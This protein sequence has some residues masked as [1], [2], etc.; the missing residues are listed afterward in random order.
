MAFYETLDDFFESPIGEYACSWEIEQYKKIVSE[1]FGYNAVQL[2]APTLD[3]LEGNQ[4]GLK[5]VCDTELAFITKIRDS[6]ETASI[7]FEELPFETESIDL[8]LLPHTLEAVDDA[9]ALIREVDR[10][11]IP[12]GRVVITGFNMMSLWG[13]RVGME[14]LGSEQFLPGKKFFS[15]RQITDWLHLLNFNVDRGAFGRYHP[16]RLPRRG[17]RQQWIEKAGDRWWPHCGALYSVSGIKCVPGSKFVGKA[18]REEG[19]FVAGSRARAEP[20]SNKS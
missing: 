20:T 10:V 3:L 17:N 13:L 16:W 7:A 9:H 15:V 6:R 18:I 14:K 4:I 11:M 1:C 5:V 19:Y 2:G 12:G 8:V